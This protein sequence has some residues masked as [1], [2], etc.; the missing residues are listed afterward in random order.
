MKYGLGYILSNG[1]VGVYFNDS[2]KIIYKPNG[3]NFIYIERKGDRTENI[4][5][6]DFNENLNRDLNKKVILLNHF[7]SYLL[8]EA[9]NTIIEKKISE[10]I[11]ENK[12]VYLKKWMKTKH[13]SL[14]RLSNKLI[15]VCFIDQTEIHLSSETK[16]ATYVNKKGER[17]TFHLANAFDSN[18][19]EMIKRLRYTKQILM[20]MLT[21]RT[22]P[23]NNVNNTQN[24]N[25]TT[26]A[27]SM[28]H[29]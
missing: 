18:N 5:A 29:L 13:A 28:S 3:M 17:L 19:I 16:L 12:Y 9:K 2:S 11:D 6:H 20:H 7:K 22:I 15:Q 8:E 23:N 24:T 25:S 27:E 21:A 10:N 4:S 14:F 26:K 1:H